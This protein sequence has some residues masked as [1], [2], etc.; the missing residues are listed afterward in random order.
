MGAIL[1]RVHSTKF[2]GPPLLVASLATL[3]MCG[4]NA[5][6]SDAEDLTRIAEMYASY[7]R[8]FPDVAGVSAEEVKRLREAGDAVLVDVREAKEREV[9]IIPGAL[10]REEF[11][12]NRADAESGAS[13]RGRGQ[14][15]SRWCAPLDL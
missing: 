8:K 5:S 1:S 13:R 4:M 9:S 10:S 12:A 6:G 14:S 2:V 15:H 11:E 3:T 7:Q